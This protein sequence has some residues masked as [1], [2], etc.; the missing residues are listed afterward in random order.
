MTDFLANFEDLTVFQLTLVGTCMVAVWFL[1]VIL[2]LFFNRKQVKL[3]AIACV[4]AGLSVIAWSAVLMWAVTGKAVEKY[5][6][7]KIRQ[8]LAQ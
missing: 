3:I 1:P 7:Q 8:R 5:L 6:P 2:A 4:P